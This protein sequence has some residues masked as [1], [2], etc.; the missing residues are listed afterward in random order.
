MKNN[1]LNR[2]IAI[3]GLDIIKDI[4]LNIFLIARIYDLAT[5][6]TKTIAM[7][8]IIEYVCIA[9]T[10]VACR[11]FFKRH[12]V[13]GL[14]IGMMFNLI[15]LIIIMRVD[16]QII[17]H[18]PMVACVF[19]IAMGTYYGP[20]QVLLGYYAAQN[21]VRYCTVSTIVNNIINVVFPVTIGA[22]IESTSFMAVTVCMLAVTATQALLTMRIQEIQ[23]SQSCDLLAF[24]KILSKNKMNK[25]ILTY[26]ITFLGGITSSVLDRTV[27]ILMMMMF[28]STMQLG[29]LTTVFAVFTILSSWMVQK[30]HKT[31][32]NW[33][34]KVSAVMPLLAV[35]L[36][37]FATNTA[38]FILYKAVSSV[39]I[40]ILTLF[41]NSSRYNV[42][43]KLSEQ[44]AAEHQT[45][46]ELALAAGRITGL[47]VLVVVNE[48]I[49]GIIA[50]K[51]MLAIIGVIIIVYANLT[52]KVSKK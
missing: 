8:Y 31:G 10:M 38:T 26:V 25:V 49:G 18:Y 36:L 37:V 27:L 2:L 7:Y 6:A 32:T 28:G 11:G 1:S 42:I 20:N 44:Y 50:I 21:S 9:I 34:I 4:Y 30:F 35:L 24:A 29:I 47:V 5:N 41:A 14:R 33:M 13:M 15:L 48:V 17:A 45:L 43:G 12:P 23:T 22:Y 46:S 16:N 51:A 19:G 39:F 40:C 52:S 3:G